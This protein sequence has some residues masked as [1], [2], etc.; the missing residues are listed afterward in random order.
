V[1]TWTKSQY[2]KTGGITVLSNVQFLTT[3]KLYAKK[4]I[5]YTAKHDAFKG[6]KSMVRNYLEKAQTLN[7]LDKDF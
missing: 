1:A 4:Q 3:K 6:T 2:A 5:K 7:L